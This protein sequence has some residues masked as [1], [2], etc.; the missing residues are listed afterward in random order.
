MRIVRADERYSSASD[1]IESRHCFSAGG[2][3]DADNVSYG[4]LIGC[5]EHVVA[6]GAGF[7]WHGHRG[8]DIISWVL[9]GELRHE[10]DLRSRVIRPGEV[11]WQATGT[12]IRHRETNASSEPLRLVQMTLVAFD[13]ATTV[14]VQEPPLA[15]GA[16]TFEVWTASASAFRACWHVFVGRGAWQLGDLALS[17]GDSV[18]GGDRLCVSGTGEL[19]VWLL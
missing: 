3:Y 7:D 10:D 2:H 1:G 16:S 4:A 14:S 13:D 6:P 5:D 11:L 8:V 19:L 17:V 9:G 12:G 18:R 15:I